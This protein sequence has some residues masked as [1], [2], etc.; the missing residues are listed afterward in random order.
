MFN[1]KFS[2]EV[3]H[4]FPFIKGIYTSLRENGYDMQTVEKI[5]NTATK[6]CIADE[7]TGGN[8]ELK[9]LNPL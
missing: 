3:Q 9:E 4:C 6:V 7:L 5:I 2:D 1:T 8:K